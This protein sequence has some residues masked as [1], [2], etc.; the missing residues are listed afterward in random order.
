MYKTGFIGAGNM[1][2]ALI[3][4]A[5]HT[6]G[7]ENV[8]ITDYDLNK[9]EELSQQTGCKTAASN[10]DIIR[11]AE[12]IFLAVKPN[13]IR[14]VAKAA[15]SVLSEELA[16]GKKHVVVT[17]AAG[18]TIETIQECIGTQIPVIR[19]MPNTPVAVGQGM[20][21][22]TGPDPEDENLKEFQEI[23]AKA[24]DFLYIPEKNFDITTSISGC[25]P[26]YTY[27]FIDALADG[28]VQVGVPRAQAIRLAA[29][30][31]LGSAQMV[32]ETG[33]H[34]D[35]L[36]DNV[37]SPGGSTIVGVTALEKNNFRYGV[38]QS[39]IRSTEKNL[40]LGK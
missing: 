38:A 31:V 40:E 33:L 12:Y 19:I 28:A 15:A 3:I 27:M 23:M 35:Q 4:A 21:L 22:L 37:C 36:K 26:A 29:K 30:T 17:I 5:C 1:G 20:I 9:A 16:N 18:I 2:G 6:I 34:P 14:E 24:G 13:V 10:D 32:L 25:T 11:N 8:I 7:A 39:I